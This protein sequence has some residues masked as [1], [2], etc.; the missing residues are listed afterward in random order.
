MWSEWSRADDHKPGGMP[1]GLQHRSK[2]DGHI[3]AVAGAQLQNSSGRVQYLQPK[4]ILGIPHVLLYPL[5]E[6]LD[7]SQVILGPDFL[8]E[9]DVDRLLSNVE[10]LH[11]LTNQSLNVLDGLARAQISLGDSLERNSG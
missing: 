9:E 11:T 3:V 5:E 8:V 4:G 7:L 2:Q 10:I 1:D 6:R